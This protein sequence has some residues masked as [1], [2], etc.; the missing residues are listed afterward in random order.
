MDAGYRKIKKLGMGGFG[1]VWKA[2]KINLGM[3]TTKRNI[4]ALKIVNIPN[5]EVALMAEREVELLKSLKPCHRSLSCYYGSK[6]VYNKNNGTYKLYLEMEFIDGE[7]LSTFSK[8]LRNRRNPNL[9][10]YLVA[11]S[12]DLSQGLSFLHNKGIIHRDIKPQN[13]MITK[14]YQPKLIDIGL[15]CFKESVCPINKNLRIQ[16]TSGGFTLGNRNCCVS[17]SGTPQYSSP[18]SL[19]YFVSYPA[20]DVWSLGA[21][22][23][24]AAFDRFVYNATTIS[25]LRQQ[26][27]NPPILILSGNRKFDDLIAWCLQINYRDRPTTSQIYTL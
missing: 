20:S 22:L 10:K 9:Y 16:Q 1:S 27:K 26:M 12:K 11:I 25:S 5:K 18:E 14:D 21:T 23:Y 17:S 15:G 13:I 24:S 7:T 6:F 19:I 2:E 3:R 8:K 4:I